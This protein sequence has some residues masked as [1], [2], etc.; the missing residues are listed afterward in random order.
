MI[1]DLLNGWAELEEAAS[2]YE[3]AEQYYDGRVEEFFSS[4]RI[5][6]AVAATGARYRFNVAKTPVNVVADRVELSA[7]TVPDDTTSSALIEQ[8]WDANDMDVHYPDLFKKVFI[9][10]D[11]YLQAWP[12]LEPDPMM[13]GE[14][15]LAGVELSV[16]GPKHCRIVYDIEN[17][18]R[19]AFVIKRWPVKSEGHECWRADLYYPD[20][21]E[22]WVSLPGA[23]LADQ[24]GWAPHL[25]EGE[26]DED[27]LIESPWGEIPFFHY[28]NALPYGV[29][30]HLAGYGCQDA[31]NKNLINQLC[32]ADTHSLPVRYALTDA[33][34][35]LDHAGN[36]S[37]PD[38]TV[39]R[40]GLD[41][42]STQM[43][44]TQPGAFLDLVGKKSV[45]QFDAAD[46]GVF[47]RPAEFFIRLMAQL[48]DT[49]M[50]YFD[51][52]GDAPSGESLRVAEAPLV[53]KVQHRQVMLRGSV[54]ETWSFVLRLLGRSVPR[55]DVRWAPAAS[56]TGASDWEVVSAKQSAGV[57]QAQTLLEAGYEAE[58]VKTWFDAAP[59]ALDLS[60]Q[61][62][63]LGKLSEIVAR[64]REG[65]DA[66]L[67][68][69]Q[70]ATAVVAQLV[71]QAVPAPGTDTA[72]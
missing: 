44:P 8:V 40:G 10:G 17:P 2:G 47:L 42:G 64:L 34:A 28:R 6:Q 23:N 61:V 43:T 16:H 69:Q 55:V 20:G 7:V 62:E 22:R 9:Y 65:V 14:L 25:D 12:I 13:D 30:E 45:G 66:G 70:E 36:D 21:V 46:P 72:A 39:E 52:T 57:P 71:R 35:E 3:E 56:A 29:P 33:G 60:R 67:I 50:H 58:Q 49:P 11:A 18:R 38:D 59:E 15:A 32:T 19:K 54:V 41:V 37:W 27:W 68:S 4:T 31:V 63:L 5:R 51:P 24:A 53:K 1:E 26:S 48:T